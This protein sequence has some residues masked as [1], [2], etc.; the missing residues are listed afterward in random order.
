MDWFIWLRDFSIVEC[1]LSFGTLGLIFYK[2]MAREFRF[3]MSL[4]AIRALHGLVIIPLLFFR[5]ETG[6]SLPVAYQI[7]FFVCWIS[8]V[9]EALLFVAVIYDVYRKA[10]MPL[11][12]LQRIG[13]VIFRWVAVVSVAVSLAIAIGPHLSSPG[14]TSTTATI[15]SMAAQIQQG[16]TVLT[17]CLLLF[18]CFAIR[19]L[20]L[21]FA[22]RIFG[23][24]LGLGVTATT[25]LIQAAWL[26]TV[27]AH[28]LYSPIYMISAAGS[29]ASVCIWGTYFALPEPQRKMILLP[30]TSPFFTW[31]RISEALGDEPGF[32]AVAGFKPDMLAAAELKVLTSGTTRVD[33]FQ[34]SVISAAARESSIA[35]ALH[36][37]A[38]SQ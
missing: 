23:V 22:S 37:I 34:S 30:T 36:S 8:A 13:N 9:L 1:V 11:K 16:T 15:T 29:L 27:G 26:S 6:L 3:L 18:V 38:V 24:A 14:S 12:G 21:T 2:G 10:M 7:Y 33:R 32:V 28:S 5:P 35:P 25:Y 31:N 19:P 20:G 4:I 17:L